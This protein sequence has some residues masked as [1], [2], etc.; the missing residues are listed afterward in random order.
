MGVI[1]AAMARE[2]SNKC[3]NIPQTAQQNMERL[4]MHIRER[5]GAVCVNMHKTARYATKL[6]DEKKYALS[7][8]SRTNHQEKGNHAISCISLTT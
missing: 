2:W 5:M 3:A 1:H 8:S 4:M 7:D 6:A